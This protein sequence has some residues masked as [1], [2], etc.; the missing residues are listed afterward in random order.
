MSARKRTGGGVEQ[1]IDENIRRV[2]QEALEEQVPDRF[3]QL[4]EQLRM[5]DK[6]ASGSDAGKR[7][8]RK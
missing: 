3:T 1:Q 5:Q 7:E 2:Y 8:A 6:T 4:L